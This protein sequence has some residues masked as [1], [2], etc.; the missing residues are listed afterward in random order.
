MVSVRIC[1]IYIQLNRE[2]IAHLYVVVDV[3]EDVKNVELNMADNNLNCAIYFI[4]ES[5]VQSIGFNV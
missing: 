1:V 3:V 4:D 2:G 5:V